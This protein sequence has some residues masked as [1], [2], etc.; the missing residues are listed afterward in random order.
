MISISLSG[1]IYYRCIKISALYRSHL[2]HPSTRYL[3]QTQTKRMIKYSDNAILMTMILLIP[4]E[5]SFYKSLVSSSVCRILFTKNMCRKFNKISFSVNLCLRAFLWI[6]C[7]GIPFTVYISCASILKYSRIPI[8]PEKQAIMFKYMVLFPMIHGLGPVWIKLGQW[9]STR[10]DL[11]P[12]NIVNVLSQLQHEAPS[13][14]YS[15]TEKVIRE[16][17][18]S[19]IENLFDS[20]DHEPIGS[21]SIAQVHR[22]ILKGTKEQVAVKVIHPNVEELLE[23]DCTILSTLAHCIKFIV[24]IA[25]WMRLSEQV[26]CFSKSLLQQLDLEVEAH[27]L[28]LFRYH[29]RNDANVDFPRPYFPLVTSRVLV[30]EYQSGRTIHS[31]VNQSHHATNTVNREIIK[32]IFKTFIKMSLLD[33]FVH[34]DLHPGNILVLLRDDKDLDRNHKISLLNR[35]KARIINSKPLEVYPKVILLDVGLVNQLSPTA[36][37]NFRDLFKTVVLWRDGFTAGRLILERSDIARKSN[38]STKI[39]NSEIEAL[40]NYLN[41]IQPGVIDPIGFCNKMGHIVYNYFTSHPPP[42]SFHM[43]L[44]KYEIGPVLTQVLHIVRDHHVKLDPQYANF[45]M[46]VI[47]IE[48]LGRQLCPDLDLLPFFK[49]AAIHYFLLR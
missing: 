36:F 4:K 24:P 37:S 28:L 8:S 35:L 49:Q 26:D 6:A 43:P 11:L 27:N 16:E 23:L 7:F 17:L 42:L 18:E 41:D 21:G 22:A 9:A 46:S 32:A 13:H 47:F 31:F 33:N 40:R 1:L 20:F 15:W 29:F 38:M 10:M 45:M 14:P 44:E 2:L 12:P 3:Q 25:H 19:S 39:D 30:E 34:A 48:G 5:S